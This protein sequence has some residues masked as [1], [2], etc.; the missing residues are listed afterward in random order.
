MEHSTKVGRLEGFLEVLTFAMSTILS[1]STELAIFNPF[2]TLGFSRAL[3]IALDKEPRTNDLA[4]ARL[5]LRPFEPSVGDEVGVVE[6]VLVVAGELGDIGG[7]EYA[8]A[9]TLCDPA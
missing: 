1:G 6:A 7:G 3:S 9:E 4:N 8:G 2:M 5:D